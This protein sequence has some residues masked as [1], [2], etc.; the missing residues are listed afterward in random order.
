MLAIEDDRRA[1]EGGRTAGGASWAARCRCRSWRDGMP[2]PVDAL[3]DLQYP[4]LL[5]SRT[6]WARAPVVRDA[7]SRPYFLEGADGGRRAW[8]CIVGTSARRRPLL[9]AGHTVDRPA[10]AWAGAGPTPSR[11]S[12]SLSWRIRDT[13]RR[14]SD[15]TPVVT[16]S[17]IG[18]PYP[19][20]R[21]RDGSPLPLAARSQ[22]R[23][24]P[25]LKAQIAAGAV[26]LNGEIDLEP[27]LG[28]P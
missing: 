15:G 3:V 26:G 10:S 21:T 14:E 4:P 22:T 25:R 28:C 2:S 16:I 7:M 23:R 6:R 9:R 17:Y 20:S 5:D 11:R 27:V 8:R 19:V 18:G 24:S 1:R 12:R 13:V